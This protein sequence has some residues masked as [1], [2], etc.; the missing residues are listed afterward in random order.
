MLDYF[1]NYYNSFKQKMF[2]TDFYQKNKG[3]AKNK[4]RNFGAFYLGQ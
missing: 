2:T 1:I 3:I 4:K